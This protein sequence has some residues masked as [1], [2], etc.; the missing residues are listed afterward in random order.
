MKITT[1]VTNQWIKWERFA[2]GTLIEYLDDTIISQLPPGR[3][4]ARQILEKFDSLYACKKVSTQLCLQDRLFNCKLKPDTALKGHM[5]EIDK[6]VRDLVACG[7]EGSEITKVWYTLNSSPSNYA[8]IK[9]AIKTMTDDRITLAFV[10]GM[11]LEHEESLMRE[12]ADTSVEALHF[13]AT[14]SG[15]SGRKRQKFISK[16]KRMFKNKQAQRCF[17]CE[18]NNHMKRDCYFYKQI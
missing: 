5:V 9:A 7:G 13:R 1:P 18:R 2:R 15:E 16:N 3:A 8:P 17:H 4:T 6:L 12:S 10:K 14:S 11:L